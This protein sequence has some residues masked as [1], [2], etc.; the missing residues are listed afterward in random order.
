VR[1][2]EAASARPA[3]AR[4]WPAP[5]QSPFA[6]TGPRRRLRRGREFGAGACAVADPALSAPVAPAGLTPADAIAAL[7]TLAAPDQAT[8]LASV[9]RYDRF[10]TI[11][12]PFKPLVVAAPARHTRPD[13][14]HR[15][16]GTGGVVVPPVHRAAPHPGAV[17]GTGGATPGGG[18]ST[19]GTTAPV[20]S[21]NPL[22]ADLD[23]SGEP[24]VVREGDAIPPDSQE[25]RVETLTSK[26]MTLRLTAGIL[27]DGSDTFTLKVGQRVTLYDQG[28]RRNLPPAPERDPA[29]QV[30]GPSARAAAGRPPGPAGGFLTGRRGRW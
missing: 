29:G 30:G 1:A 22:E 20:A 21:P 2:D 8:L 17:P 12:D 27:P 11:R 26:A 16:A 10:G 7:G 25:F 24:L 5:R 18:T 4:W 6:V 9:G 15:R 28:E 23:V 13:A 3:C 14:R 19:G